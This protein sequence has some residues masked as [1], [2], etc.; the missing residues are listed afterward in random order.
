MENSGDL[1]LVLKPVGV[2]RTQMRLKFD[3][4]HQPED[5]EEERNTV[6]LFP[7]CRYEIGLRNLEGFDR[8]WLIWWFHKNS[9]WKPL[10][11]PP[12]G[13]AEKRGVFATRSPHRPNPV[14]ITCVRLLAISGT[15][16]TVG[17]CDLLDGTPILDIKPYI[18]AVDSFPDSSE[19][20]L[21]EIDDWLAAPPSFELHLSPLASEQ[22]GW[23][24]AV[25]GIDFYA[26]A[27]A[28]L[29]R[30]PSPHRTRRIS[31]MRNGKFRM[32]CGAWKLVFSVIDKGVHVECVT[33]GYPERLLFREPFDRAPDRDAQVA[34]GKK[35]P[36]CRLLSGLQDSE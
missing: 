19:G 5:G 33:T 15:T 20:W 30:D 25:W 18:P 6:E 1:T 16:L 31:R 17:N 13:P 12:R 21:T 22:I 32:G 7:D 24:R 36:D 35:W 28:M 10:V 34:F 3:A 4:P 26:R 14:G 11:L 2:I 29:S 9:V 23:L 27:S 8:I